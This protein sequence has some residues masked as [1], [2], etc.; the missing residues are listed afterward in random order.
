MKTTRWYLFYVEGS[1]LILCVG[2]LYSRPSAAT[3][4]K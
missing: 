4:S 2:L 1:A 3:G